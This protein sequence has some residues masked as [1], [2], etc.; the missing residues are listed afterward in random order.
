MG[1]MIA[2][3][4]LRE[5]AEYRYGPRSVLQPGDRFR[6]GGGPIYLT[7]DGE[8]V[9]MYERGVFVFRRYCEQG[10]RKWL[11]AYRADRGGMAVLWMGRTGPSPVV[12]GLRRR[13][14]RISRRIRPGQPTNRHRQ[15]RRAKSCSNTT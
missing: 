15:R 3:R 6:V 2:K 9:P 13:P 4:K 11:E 5:H 7:A 1:A 14:Y 12:P 8:R 10:A